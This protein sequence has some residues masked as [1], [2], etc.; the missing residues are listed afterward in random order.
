MPAGVKEEMQALLHKMTAHQESEESGKEENMELHTKV[1]T[2]IQA[3]VSGYDDRP[4]RSAAAAWCRLPQLA[5][6]R[7]MICVDKLMYETYAEM[8]IP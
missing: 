4:E 8:Q 2:G 6:T 3:I 7:S 5:S 1:L